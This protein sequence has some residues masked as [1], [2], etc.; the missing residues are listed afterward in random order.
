MNLYRVL[1]LTFILSFVFLAETLGQRS[2]LFSE[3]SV[4][5][6]INK[7]KEQGKFLFVDTYAEWCIPCRKM[8][9]V[10][11]DRDVAS[12]F[13]NNYLNIKINMDG[14]NGRTTYNDYDV[15]FL[16]IMMIFDHEGKIKYKTDKLLTAQELLNIGI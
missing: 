3:L 14:P 6:G 9:K 8:K 13:N 7:A 1:F 12:Y 15:V 5:A 2:M 16:P 10:F 11:A 4:K